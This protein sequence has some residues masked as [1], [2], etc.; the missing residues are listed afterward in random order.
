MTDSDHV[1]QAWRQHRQRL[2]D[3]AY[4]MLGSVSDAEDVVQEAYTRLMRSD[5]NSI[6]DLRG[7]LITVTGRL[8]LDHLKS[9]DARRRAYVG[10]WLPEPLVELLARVDF[11]PNNT[12]TML[13]TTLIGARG[14]LALGRLM[15]GA[16]R[17][18]PERVAGLTI[19]E[20][21]DGFHLPDDARALM[22]MLVRTATYVQDDDHV[23]ADVAVTQIRLA[24]TDGAHYVHGG[25]ATLVDGLVTAARRNGAEVRTGPSVTSVGASGAGVAVVADGQEISAGA[26]VLAAGTP[27]ATAVVLDR[28]PEAWASLGPQV[29][30]SCLD[31]GLRARPAKPVLYGIDRPFYL[32]DHAT[33]AEGLCPD[34]GG[35]V[36]VLRYLAP[37]EE[38]PV[39]TL[40]ESMEEHARAAGI[41]PAMIEERRFLHRM[42]VVGA[43]PTPATGGLA[44]RP[45]VDSTGVPGVFVAG[46]WVGPRGWLSD[47]TIASGEGAGIAAAQEA[48]DRA[49][50]RAG[51]TSIGPVG[52]RPMGRG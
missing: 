37:G 4:R 36:H 26:V 49:G 16:K 27:D 50:N 15:A 20:W 46:D 44:G 21:L 43:T 17:W 23:S 38:I 24:M 39:D 3:I 33:R 25:W 7:W 2:L 11:L 9:A 14:K 31:L 35:L 34:G 6:D 22:R 10:P 41:D 47:C 1:D 42:T 40:R 45:G 48:A 18:Q 51:V 19:G 28:R 30:V 52:D 32:A 29:E 8:C 12:R 13:R 5:I